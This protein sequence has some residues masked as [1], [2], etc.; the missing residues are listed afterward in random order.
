LVTAV[1]RRND[2]KPN[3]T[4]FGGEMRQP[5]IQEI[6]RQPGLSATLGKDVLGGVATLATAQLLSR[7]IGFGFTLTLTHLLTLEDFGTFNIAMTTATIAGLVQDLGISRTVVKK[8]SRNPR[9]AHSLVGQLI[10]LKLALSIGAGMILVAALLALGFDKK[11]V[12][13]SALFALIL[14]SASLWLLME[15]AAQGLGAIRLLSLGY[16]SVA[17]SQSMLGLA[18]AVLSG[19]NL[20]IVILSVLVGNVA[21]TGIMLWGFTAIA[22]RITPSINLLFWGRIALHSLPYLGAAA[23]VAALGRIEALILGRFTGA[24]ETA[25]FVVAFKIFETALFLAYSAQIAMNSTVAKLILVDRARFGRW[26]AWETSLAAALVVPAVLASVLLAPSLLGLIFPPAYAA[27]ALPLTILAG[28][29]PISTLQV[30]ASG[31]LMLT[32]HQRGVLAIS[33]STLA[34]Q[35]VLNFALVPPFGPVGAAV[36]FAGGQVFAAVACVERTRA[37]LLQDWRSLRPLAYVLLVQAAAGLLGLTVG[38]WSGAPAGCAVAGLLALA[39]LAGN[40]R[41]E[42]PA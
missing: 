26:F 29:F 38:F 32:N 31:S 21:A 22:G 35:V 41:I 10:Y 19:G 14:P 34:V 8:V 27:A 4:C 42:P 7:A 20:K 6:A 12:A 2:R 16:L 33:L 36:A 25:I 40:L 15:N 18:A 1:I 17:I 37:W 23:A 5:P 3:A 24:A 30:F 11:I 13:A 28:A 39:G 9:A